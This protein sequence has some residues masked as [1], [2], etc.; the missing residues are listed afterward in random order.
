MASDKQLMFVKE[1]LFNFK[2][3]HGAFQASHGFRGEFDQDETL[4]HRNSSCPGMAK[5]LYYK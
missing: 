2:L 1:P 4:L 5:P 3:A